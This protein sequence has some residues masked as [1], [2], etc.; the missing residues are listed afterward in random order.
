MSISRFDL[1]V[2]VTA[3]LSLTACGFTQTRH[4][5]S[6][7]WQRADTTSAL[8]MQG[9]KAQ[10]MLHQ[11]ISRCVTEVKELTK[12][13]S[14]REAIPAKTIN[15][16]PDPDSPEGHMEQW[17]TPSHDGA[18]Y[19]EHLE[20]HDFETCM[21]AKGWE[22]VEHVPYNI[23]DNAREV[24]AKTILKERYKSKTPSAQFRFKDSERTYSDLNE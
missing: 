2:S 16:Y 1:V 12:L 24:Y 21:S 11:D 18:L 7:F 14:I 9:P 3:L 6:H 17:E 4:T 19:S 5:E 13:G 15:E 20:F 10:Q 8:Y 22:R 23:A